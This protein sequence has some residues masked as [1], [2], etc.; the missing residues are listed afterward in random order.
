MIPADRYYT[1]MVYGSQG[2]YDM[3]QGNTEQGR[4][5]MEEAM[6]YDPYT[7]SYPLDIARIYMQEYFQTND[8][9]AAN[10]AKTY[11]DL[12]LEISPNSLTNKV[13][14][15][16]FLYA[17]GYYDEAAEVAYEVTQMIPL[18]MQFYQVLADKARTAMLNHA[19]EIAAYDL[20]GEEKESHIEPM[21][22]Y[23]DWI[24]EIPNRIEEKKSKIVGLHEFM[25]SPDNLQTTPI[26]HLAL[27]QV[28]FLEGDVQSALEHLKHGAQ[29]TDLQD[30]AANWLYALRIVANVDVQIP[31][32]AQIDDD[33]VDAITHL[34]GILSE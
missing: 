34:Y 5:Y 16:N 22:K 19:I 6:K 7:P 3:Y 14:C 26:I 8:P 2:I 13:S 32:D 1:G 20:E 4:Q 29:S 12:A 28:Y 30:E 33:T 24:K 31:E 27:G 18:D 21:R 11:I 17:I 10:M 23:A 15:I 25:W 9:A